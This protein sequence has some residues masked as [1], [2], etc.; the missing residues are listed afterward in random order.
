M[1]K[2]NVWVGLVLSGSMFLYSVFI[3]LVI[4]FVSDPSNAIIIVIMLIF[5]AVGSI[6]LTR[7]LILRN[8][9]KK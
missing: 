4:R 3:M 6:N 7:G 5:T 8:S 1:K 9:T 2:G